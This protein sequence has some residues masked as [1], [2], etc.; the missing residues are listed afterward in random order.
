MKTRIFVI[1]GIIVSAVIFG[2]LS[3]Q[4]P[5]LQLVKEHYN[6]EII[7]LKETYHIGESYSFSYILSGFGSSCGGISVIFPENKTNNFT[8]GSIP[9]CL[10]TMPTNFVLDMQKTYGKTYGHIALKE[11]GN[12]TVT[13]KFEKGENGPTIATKSFI[14]D[15]FQSIKE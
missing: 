6:L 5:Q 4:E 2:V 12:Y 14:V 3:F 13:V 7:G 11:S 9:S 10:K 1:I 8:E 15:D